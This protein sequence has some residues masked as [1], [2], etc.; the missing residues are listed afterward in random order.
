MTIILDAAKTECI[1]TQNECDDTC[2]FPPRKVSLKPTKS[3]KCEKIKQEQ[4]QSGL[5]HYSAEGLL[6]QKG[7]PNA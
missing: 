7:T 5:A 2:L 1:T 4:D 6:K 3:K